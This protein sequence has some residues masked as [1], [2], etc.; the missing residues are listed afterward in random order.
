MFNAPFSEFTDFFNYHL[1]K[2]QLTGLKSWN[3]LHWNR[4]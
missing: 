1:L 3:D 4:Q 2:Q